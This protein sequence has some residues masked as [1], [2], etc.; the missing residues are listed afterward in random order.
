MVSPSQEGGAVLSR[1][2]RQTW[3]FLEWWGSA[4]PVYWI[5]PQTVSATYKTQESWELLQK[6]ISCSRDVYEGSGFCFPVGLQGTSHGSFVALP[7]AEKRGTGFVSLHAVSVWETCTS[8]CL[9][10]RGLSVRVFLCVPKSALYCGQ[11]LVLPGLHACG[12]KG[13]KVV[14][15]KVNHE[16]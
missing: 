1:C 6:Y 11:N 8:Q 7:T 5:S 2:S 10:S 3:C 15:L 13:T 12:A 14:K 9:G 4:T 16:S